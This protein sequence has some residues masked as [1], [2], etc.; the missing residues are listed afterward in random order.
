MIDLTNKHCGKVLVLNRLKGGVW[1]CLCEC[2]K[3]CRIKTNR[4]LHRSNVSCGCHRQ[5]NLVGKKFGRLTVICKIESR[6]GRR[7]WE[8]KCDCGK[9]I[10]ISGFRLVRHITRSCGCYKHDET[11]KRQWKGHGEISGSLWK[12]ILNQAKSRGLSVEITIEDA[13]NLFLSQERRCK[14]TRLPLVFSTGYIKADGTASLDRID[15]SIGYTKNNIQWVH[16]DVNQMKMDLA[17]DYFIDLCRRIVEIND[18]EDSYNKR[19]NEDS[20]G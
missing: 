19:G 6:N 9:I 3:K 14:L 12:R 2:G 1:E 4:L 5:P 20:V 18:G 15:S 16:K 8:C 7:Y 10:Q 17:Q 13:W 11:I